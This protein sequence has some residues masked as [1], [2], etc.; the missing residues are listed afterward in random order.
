MP[1]PLPAPPRLER[2]RASQVTLLVHAA[3]RHDLIGRFRPCREHRL[4]AERRHHQGRGGGGQASRGWVGQHV[5][6]AAQR[7]LKLAPADLVGRGHLRGTLQQHPGGPH[8]LALEQQ[9][10]EHGGVGAQG[11]RKRL[12]CG[13][14]AACGTRTWSCKGHSAMVNGQRSKQWSTVNGERVPESPS[15]SG[16]WVAGYLTLRTYCSPRGRLRSSKA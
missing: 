16:A 5:L 4:E 2:G 7:D 12:A 9:R 15:G 6:G 8:D 11:A 13:G 1:H 10:L 14:G 3:G